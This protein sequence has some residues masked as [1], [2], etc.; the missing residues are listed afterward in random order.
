MRRSS[1]SVFLSIFSSALLALCACSSTPKTGAPSQP[2]RLLVTVTRTESQDRWTVTYRTS[3]PV[4]ELVF[5]RQVN[6][7]RA[8]K[9]I[10]KSPE[11]RIETIDGKERIH[12]VSGARFDT[13]TF[14]FAS[15]YDHTPKDY[16]F[17]RAFSDGSLVLYT[18]HFNACPE[19]FECEE[20]LRFQFQGRTS[21]RIIAL[22]RVETSKL[23]WVDVTHRG[24]Y[25]YFGQIKPLERKFLTAIIDPAL[26]NWLEK[27][28]HET[29]PR[30]FDFYAKK[31]GFALPFK[32]FVFLDYSTAGGKGVRN[33]SGGTLPG[34]IQLSIQGKG[35][36]KKDGKAFADLGHFLAHEAAHLW[37]GQLFPYSSGDMWMH[38]GGADAFSYLALYRLDIVNREHFFRLQAAAYN[39]C[40]SQLKNRPLK[41]VR[42]DPNFRAHYTCGSMVALLTHSAV[43]KKNASKD[44][45]DFWSVLFQET[46][47]RGLKAYD[48][49]IYFSKLEEMSGDP[50]LTKR[51]RAFLNGPTDSS[52]SFLKK[53][54]ELLGAKFVSIEKDL[55]KE[56]QRRQATDLVRLLMREDCKEHYGLSSSEDGIE[57]EAMKDCKVFAKSFLITGI[58]PHSIHDGAAAYDYVFETCGIPGARVRFTAKNAKDP[59][60]TSCPKEMPKRVP[61]LAIQELPL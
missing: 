26:P 14:E 23:E 18:G 2:F 48:E 52:S 33:Y 28:F 7:F 59:L 21:D 53:E 4:S 10:P 16:E 49:E 55:P 44:L 43:K 61:A 36:E 9:W 51:L 34:L 45:F 6:R 57:T 56:Y 58:G 30:I 27:R 20:P 40:V 50:E 29:L 41:E 25:V 12:S 19:N 31:T 39:H 5:D 3:E 37:N 46:R 42:E 13:A 17:F 15:Y 32:P 54:L 8:V 35:W 1:P 60:E 22:G 24:T 38:E 11:I 47:A